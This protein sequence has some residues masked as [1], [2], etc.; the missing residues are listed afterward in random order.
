MPV[1][2]P[3]AAATVAIVVL[4][5]VHVPPVDALPNVVAKPAQTVGVPVMVTGVLYT[6]TAAVA[7]RLQPNAVVATNE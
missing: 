3:V 2:T 1:T 7:E 4:L 5:L 6:A